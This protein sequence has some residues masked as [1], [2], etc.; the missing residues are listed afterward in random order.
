MDK[1]QIRH[2]LALAYAKTKLQLALERGEIGR[3]A[4]EEGVEAAHLLREW[5]RAC[6]HELSQ[7]KDEDLLDVWA[8]GLE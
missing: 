3:G 8:M 2:D 1:N 6:F 7:I 4:A 5:Y